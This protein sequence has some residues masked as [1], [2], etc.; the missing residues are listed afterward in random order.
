MTAFTCCAGS[1]CQNLTAKDNAAAYTGSKCN[2]YHVL[3]ALSTTAPHLTKS[4]YICI[5]TSLYSKSCQTTKN[6][7]YIHDVPAKV[8]CLEYNAFIIYRSWYTDTDTCYFVFCNIL[9]CHL[10]Q[11]GL[12]YVRE[13]ILAILFCSGNDLPLIL[14]I[15]FQVKKTELYSC[16]SYIDTE[17]ILIHYSSSSSLFLV[18]EFCTR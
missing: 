4:C 6:F 10:V 13:N 8:D 2:K 7:F 14:H 15:S 3:E 1:T 9:L 11:N 16:A 5:I 12:G 17:T 18:N